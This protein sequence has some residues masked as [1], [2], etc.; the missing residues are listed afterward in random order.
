MRLGERNSKKRGG[1]DRTQAELE[2]GTRG[3]APE[4]KGRPENG[5]S[6]R[7]KREEIKNMKM[8]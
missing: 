7:Q 2:E 1:E 4:G 6:D 8:P 3:E 5:R